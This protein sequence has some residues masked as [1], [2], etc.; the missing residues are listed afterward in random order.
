MMR[1]CGSAE[2]RGRVG[3]LERTALRGG[4]NDPGRRFAQLLDGGEDR[5]GLEQHPLAAAAEVVVGLAVLVGGPVAELVGADFH[6]PGVA[7]AAD[8]ALVQ[9]RE[10]DLG[11]EGEDVD[12]H[13][14]RDE[15]RSAR[16]NEGERQSARKGGK[17]GRGTGPCWLAAE[18]L[19]GWTCRV[20]VWNL[21]LEAFLVLILRALDPDLAAE[22]GFDEGV[23]VAVHDGLDVA[24]FLAGAEVDDLLVG[25]EDVGTD[26]V[27]PADVALFTVGAVGLGLLLVLLELVELGA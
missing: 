8:D 16:A 10:R 24:G 1:R 27:A 11:E 22:H 3:L 15:K 17:R 2:S 18:L 12:A 4:Q 5:L 19:R 20:G 26:L 21:N 13:G 7:G 14:E 25:L 9:R 23:E 6:D